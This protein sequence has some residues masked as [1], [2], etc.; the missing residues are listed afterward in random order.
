MKRFLLVVWLALL[1]ASSVGAETV[2]LS[3]NNAKLGFILEMLS[4]RIGIKIIPAEGLGERTV[5]AYLEN[6]EAEEALDVILAAHGLFRQ[7]MPGTDIFVV[8]SGKRPEQAET[9]HTNIE[10]VPLLKVQASEAK[11]LLDGLGFGGMVT[12]DDRTNSFLAKGSRAQIEE[13]KSVVAAF[14]VDYEK[15]P[16]RTQAFTLKYAQLADVWPLLPAVLSRGFGEKGKA[17]V[18]IESFPVEVTSTGA[19]GGATTS[20][21]TGTTSTGTGTTVVSVGGGTLAGRVSGIG[22][23]AITG[24]VTFSGE[25]SQ[26]FTIIPDYRTNAIIAV[27]TENFL[28]EVGEVVAKLDVRVPQIAIEAV[29]VELTED[30]TRNLGIQWGT[31]TGS[32]GT[33]VGSVTYERLIPGDGASSSVAKVAESFGQLTA[34]LKA[35]EGKGKANILASPRVITL[36]D[37]PATIRLTSNIPVAP[38]VTTTSGGGAVATTVTEYEY[39]DIGITLVA[40]PHVTGDGSIVMELEP[41]VVTAKKSAFFPDA[42]DTSERSTATKVTVKDGGTLVIGGLL[43]TENQSTRSGVPLLGRIFPFLFSSSSKQGKKTDLVIFVSPKIVTEEDLKE[44]EAEKA[45]R[46]GGTP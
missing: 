21:P 2:T 35:L 20:T 12:V 41:K 42:V 1:L 9:E 36:N 22:S 34:D 45:A 38:K 33:F 18:N 19:R 15:S 10:V 31:A 27:G 32:L 13:L 28:K 5:T 25:V 17:S 24:K 40:I 4:K 30:A 43:S 3:L 23:P 44:A 39:R 8:S 7:K 46:T 26:G 29:L 16:I 11:K 6:V 37:S 14:D